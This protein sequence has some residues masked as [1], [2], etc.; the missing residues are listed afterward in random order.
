MYYVCEI[1]DGLSEY[2][3]GRWKEEKQEEEP[4]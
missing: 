4:K 3:T 1:T 2:G